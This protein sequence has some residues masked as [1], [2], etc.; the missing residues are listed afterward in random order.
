MTEALVNQ[1]TSAPTRKMVA[2]GVTGLVAPIVAGFLVSALP[3]LSEACGEEFGV[4][5]T[6]VGVGI[7]QGAVTF[8]A[9]YMKRNSVADR[10]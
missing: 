6:V 7:A 10:G 3:G 9:G 2:V 5:A 8:L 1:P 4:A